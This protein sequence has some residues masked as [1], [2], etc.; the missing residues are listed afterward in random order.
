MLFMFIHLFQYLYRHVID[1]QKI[2]IGITESKLNLIRILA[3]I[4]YNFSAFKPIIIERLYINTC[5]NYV[6]NKGK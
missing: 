4:Q 3:K 5:T 2:R 6:Q 1:L